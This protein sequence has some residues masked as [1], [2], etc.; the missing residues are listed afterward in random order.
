M[1]VPSLPHDVIYR[2]VGVD[3]VETLT[4]NGWEPVTVNRRFADLLMNRIMEIVRVPDWRRVL[5]YGFVRAF[6]W[7]AWDDWPEWIEA[8]T[9]LVLKSR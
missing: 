8:K 7:W 2:K 5:A 6:G 4:A 9:G 1:E 3:A